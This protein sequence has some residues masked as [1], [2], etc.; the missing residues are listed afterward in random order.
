MTATKGTDTSLAAAVG[1]SGFVLGFAFKDI[2]SHFLAG[3]LLLV[4]GT[5]R[6]GDQIVV[7][8]FEGT[9]ERIELRALYL[10]TYDNRLV[11][12]PNGDVFSAAITSNTASPHR[13][14]SFIIPVS[15]ACDI[16]RA[17]QVA[18]DAMK[19]TLGVLEDP[20]PDVVV[21]DLT[22]TGVSLRARFSTSSARSDYVSV[23]SDCMKNVKLAF[24]HQNIDATPPTPAPA[25]VPTPTPATA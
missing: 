24:T 2:L 9:V 14:R 23:G 13:R 8:D 21:E 6:I 20:V 1:I 25:P 4:G 19:A 18:V 16:E 15:H 11:I 17:Q 3:I 10:R 5:F 12:I 22:A 7:R